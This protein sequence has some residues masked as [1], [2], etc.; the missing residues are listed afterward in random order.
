MGL[1]KNPTVI[2]SGF[3]ILKKNSKRSLDISCTRFFPRVILGCFQFT[4]L[5]PSLT[6]VFFISFVLVFFS[7]CATGSV[8]LK[9]NGWVNV[10]FCLP[11]KVHNL[12]QGSIHIKVSFL[13]RRGIIK[14]KCAE[15]KYNMQESDRLGRVEFSSENSHSVLLR[16]LNHIEPDQVKPHEGEITV[17]CFISSR[18]RCS[19]C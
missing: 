14:Q 2:M 12:N 9:I 5:R 10:S 16:N 3:R 18:E 19:D 15:I 6:D 7:L 11:H 17:V 1:S 4:M 8:R 13:Q